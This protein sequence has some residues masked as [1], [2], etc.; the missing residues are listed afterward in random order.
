MLEIQNATKRYLGKTAVSSATASVSD[1]RLVALLGPNGS[2]KTT[3]MKMIAGLTRPDG[4][5]ITFNGDP[6]G[7]KTKRQI[8]YMPTENYFYSYMTAGDVG[9]YYADFFEDFS[10]VK[11]EE[12]LTKEK[13]DLKQ[14]ARAMSSG[15]LAKLKLAAAFARSSKL[16]MLDEPLNGIDILARE[17]TLALIRENHTGERAMIVSSHLVDELETMIDDVIFMKDGVIALA[18]DAK[19]LQAERGQTVVE[20]YRQIYGEGEAIQNVQAD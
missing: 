19:A 18:G 15:M 20:M 11:Y 3:L 10:R 16:T 8:C 4:G 6:I 14:K 13:L 17:R 7:V 9:R 1:G 12:L 2:G 5:T